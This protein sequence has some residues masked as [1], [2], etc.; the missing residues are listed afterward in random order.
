MALE[1]LPLVFR[2]EAVGFT[3]CANVSCLADGC[4][5]AYHSSSDTTGKTFGCP[6]GEL[7]LLI[8]CATGGT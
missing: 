4:A 6:E 5:S 7:F 1:V 3:T 8:F 2:G